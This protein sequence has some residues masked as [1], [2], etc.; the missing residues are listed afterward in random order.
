MDRAGRVRHRRARPGRVSQAP[1]RPDGALHRAARQPAGGVQALRDTEF[2]NP[3]MPTA[4]DLLPLLPELV[5]VGMAFAL[6]ML[7][8]FLAERQRWITH[9]L[10]IG[11][12]VVVAALVATGTGGQ[13]TVLNGMFVRDVAA[14]VLKLFTCLVSAL[15][16]VYA[17]P[18]LRERGLYKGEVPVLVMFAT[19]GMM[20]LVSSGS[21]VMVYLGL[22]MLA[23]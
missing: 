19:T 5:L 14:D 8:L 15:S 11:T 12:L 2:M 23:L 13:G 22:E 6:L 18:F 1:D 16:L 3:S 7:D 10:A 4:A 9:V 21:L 20:L 17:W